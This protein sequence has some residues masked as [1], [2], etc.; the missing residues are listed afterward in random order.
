VRGISIHVRQNAL[1]EEEPAQ[2]FQAERGSVAQ[3]ATIH[4]PQGFVANWATNWHGTEASSFTVLPQNT[5]RTCPSAEVMSLPTIA[6]VRRSSF[7]WNAV[8]RKMLMW[9]VRS[10]RLSSGNCNE[11]SENL[12]CGFFWGYFVEKWHFL[13]KT[14]ALSSVRHNVLTGL[15]N[16]K[17]F[18]FSNR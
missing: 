17:N 8:L 16:T 4:E 13:W 7:A 14:D 5:S 15:M 10:M 3:S 12:L 1:Q 6:P 2:Q 9:L 11:P 18:Y